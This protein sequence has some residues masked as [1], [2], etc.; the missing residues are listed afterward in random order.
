M[1][2]VTALLDQPL[3]HAS[4]IVSDAL[5]VLRR[6][7]ALVHEV[8]VDPDAAEA[9][10]WAEAELA[11]PV[12]HE[13]QSL[14]ERAVTWVLEQLQNAR[15]VVTGVD[16]RVAA[17]V[18]AALVVVAGVIALLVAGPVGRARRAQRSA[19]VFGSDTRTAAEL[20]ASADAFAT[21]GRWSEAVLD[22][23]RAM[24]RALEERALLDERPGRTAHEAAEEAGTRLPSRAEDLRRAGRL[25]DDLCYGDAAA[26]PEDDVWL[27][28]VHEQ[29]AAT[30]AVELGPAAPVASTAGV[31]VKAGDV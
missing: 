22:R 19:E 12:Y 29:V 5:I 3:S 17:L 20:L 4:S 13:R 28:H 31:G 11:D 9:A 18:V 25:F 1:H 21:Q 8:P 27:R 30:R 2:S 7:P 26:G 6:L 14:L 24:L 10:R 23:F 16:P 15:V